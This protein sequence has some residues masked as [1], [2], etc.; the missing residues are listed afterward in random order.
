MRL[1]G[2]IDD[3]IVWRPGRVIGRAPRR[4]GR[5]GRMGRL[6]GRGLTYREA[7]AAHMPDDTVEGAELALAVG[8]TLAAWCANGRLDPETIPLSR[9][10]IDAICHD[11]PF[12]IPWSQLHWPP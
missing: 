8:P 1:N 11:H 2:V 4:G 6:L 3:P 12:A 9:A 7:K 10:L 5:N